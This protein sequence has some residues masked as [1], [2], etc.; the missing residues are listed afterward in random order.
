M[1][2]WFTPKTSPQAGISEAGAGVN[3]IS[4]NYRLSADPEYLAPL[5]DAARALQ[6]LRQNAAD[7]SGVF[8]QKSGASRCFSKGPNFSSSSLRL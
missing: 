3:F 2:S 4:A 8:T 6:F 1:P 7:L 5:L